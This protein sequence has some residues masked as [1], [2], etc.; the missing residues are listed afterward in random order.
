MQDLIA[1]HLDRRVVSQIGLNFN[2]I[3]PLSI[4]F[5]SG[6]LARERRVRQRG[7]RAIG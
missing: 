3:S 7:V 6:V 2:V 5:F 4:N 1:N